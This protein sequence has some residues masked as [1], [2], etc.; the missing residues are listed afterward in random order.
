MYGLANM[1]LFLFLVNYI[2]ALVVIQLLRGDL[3][4][5]ATLNFGQLWNAFLGVY[6]VFSSENWTDVLYTAA[7]PEVPLRQSA[8]VVLFFAGWMF[9]ANCECS[10]LHVAR[11]DFLIASCTHR[12]RAA[13]VH[14]RHQRELRHRRRV[15]AKQTGVSLLG[16]AP[17]PT[18]SCDMDSEAQPVP[19]VQGTAEGY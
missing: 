5:D 14:C 3:P 1:T 7:V 6:Q 9:F 15:K 16:F 13:N 10:T 2:A 18:G 12:Y 19:V 8:V 17:S 11:F 4:G